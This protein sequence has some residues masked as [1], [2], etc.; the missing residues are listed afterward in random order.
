M[1]KDIPKTDVIREIENFFDN[2]K[3]KSPEEI[4][5]IKKL[6]MSYSIKLGEKRKLFCK[7]CFFPFVDPSIRIKNNI[8]TITCDHCQHKNRWKINY[9]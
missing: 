2:L 5:K 7:K 6:A 9:S 3:E 8:I 1:K 4:K